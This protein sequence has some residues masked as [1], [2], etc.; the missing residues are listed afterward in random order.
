MAILQLDPETFHKTLAEKEIVVVQCWASWCGGCS[1]FETVFEDASL[2][3]PDVTFGKIDTGRQQQLTRSLGVSQ[4]PSLLVFREGVLL[5]RL[6]GAVDAPELD[7]ILDQARA[8]DM[9][10]VRAELEREAREAELA[11]S[12]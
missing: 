3:H 12:M 9:N 6:A 1:A 4:V 5:L 10:V 2:D 8:L 7:R 11:V